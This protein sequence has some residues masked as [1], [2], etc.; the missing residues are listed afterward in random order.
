MKK[1]FR[2]L[3]IATAA[4]LAV[5][6]MTAFAEEQALPEATNDAIVAVLPEGEAPATPAPTVADVAADTAAPAAPVAPAVQVNGES[7]TFTDAQPVIQ[8]DRVF[9]PFRSRSFGKVT[10]IV[11]Y[12]FG[13]RDLFLGYFA[14][15]F[16]CVFRCWTF[17]II[18]I[19]QLAGIF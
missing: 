11:L 14:Y 2:I 18:L 10:N 15:Q 4:L 9:I 3:S 1:Q 12:V 7:L 5:S 16:A 13:N 17:F 6:P 19:L 8:N